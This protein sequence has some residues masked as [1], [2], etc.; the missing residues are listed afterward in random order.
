MLV[1]HLSENKEVISSITQLPKEIKKTTTACAEKAHALAIETQIALANDYF[2]AGNYQQ[3]IDNYLIAINLQADHAPTHYNLGLAY[4]AIEDQESALQALQRACEL[5]PNHTRAHYFLGYTYQQK[6]QLEK[7]ALDNTTHKNSPIVEVSIGELIDKIT[8]LEIKTERIQDK[9]KLH[10]IHKEL[11]TLKDV[12]GTYVNKKN[13]TNQLFSLIQE[14]KST[15]ETLWSIEDN[16]REKEAHKEFD[17]QFIELARSVYF[18][19]D[20]R[21]R[22]KRAI[23]DLLGSRLVEE[24]LYKSY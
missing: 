5:D 6:K 7:K 11:Y 18:T 21:G 1:S 17:T 14:L 2:K 13:C 15:N 4:L 22:I 24:K 23:N 9:V 8:I 16:I 20:E 19:N 10:N 3:A 12:F